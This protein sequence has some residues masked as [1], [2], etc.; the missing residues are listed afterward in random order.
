MESGPGCDITF[1]VFYT[2]P[3]RPYVLYSLMNKRY[4]DTFPEVKRLGR[5]VDQP[6]LPSTEV[7]NG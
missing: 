3:D 2:R 1:S 7:K 5:G 4:R 6:P